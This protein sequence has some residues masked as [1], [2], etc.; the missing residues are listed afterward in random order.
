MRVCADSNTPVYWIGE[1]GIRFYA[2]GIT[3]NH[4]NAMPR[5]HAAAWADCVLGTLW[6]R[7]HSN[8]PRAGDKP[9]MAEDISKNCRTVNVELAKFTRTGVSSI[10]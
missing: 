8:Q 2:F 5:K 3:P 10:S 7:A 4:E 6:T 9:Q 1:D